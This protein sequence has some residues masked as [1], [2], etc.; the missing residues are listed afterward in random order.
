MQETIQKQGTSVLNGILEIS[1][2][3]KSKIVALL[4]G[5]IDSAVMVAKLSMKYKVYGLFI[6]YGQLTVT[7]D[8][9]AAC[10]IAK[11]YSIP[12]M[13]LQVSEF[14]LIAQSLL[15]GGIQSKVVPARN[16]FLVSLAAAYAITIG[17]K[18][19]AYGA[20]LDDSQDFPDCRLAFTTELNHALDLGYGI[21]LLMPMQSQSK[22]EIV[23][24]A[25]LLGVPLELTH[26]CY[27]SDVPCQQCD[28]C[29]QRKIALE[30][31]QEAMQ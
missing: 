21:S 14:S 3:S 16:I 4:S 8:H 10:K 20:N 11:Y 26:S 7:S 24:E 5:G 30:T 22:R 28:A 18:Y 6:D 1:E 19:V 15:T 2:K 13:S 17:A 23:I 25:R 31:K 29:K 27:V 12:L 9:E